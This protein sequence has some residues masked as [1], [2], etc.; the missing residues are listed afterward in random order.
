MPL[1]TL[2]GHPC[3]GKSLVAQKLAAYFRDKAPEQNVT[4]IEENC[5]ASKAMCFA[6][7]TLEKRMRSDYLSAVERVLNAQ[8]TVI[9]DGLNYIK[10]L[11]YQLYCMARAASTPH[12]VIFVSCPESVCLTNLHSRQHKSQNDCTLDGINSTN[13][14]TDSSV[15]EERTDSVFSHHKEMDLFQK[16]SKVEDYSEK[17]IHDLCMR[18][19]EP[20]YAARWDGPLFTI[21]SGDGDDALMEVFE[22]VRCV[23]EGSTVRPPTV[24]T[25]SSLKSCSSI[26]LFDRL[27]KE[28]QQLT[29]ALIKG[30]KSCGGAPANIILNSEIE[31]FVARPVTSGQVQALRRQFLKMCKNHPPVEV[32]NVFVQ[33]LRSNLS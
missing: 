10:G 13:K 4:L 31:I 25:Q 5:G 27:E 6:N 29:E 3:S 23:L 7:A 15:V 20:D 19:E 16:E 30:L 9:A 2:T 12:C 28:T 33:Y 11:R 32:T 24:A 26:D 18:Y 14:L 22:G 17:T 21:V 1:V 8:T